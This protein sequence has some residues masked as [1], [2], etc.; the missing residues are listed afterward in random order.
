MVKPLK[1]VKEVENLKNRFMLIQA[2]SGFG[3][4]L[5]NIIIGLYFKKIYNYDVYFVDTISKHSK[6]ENKTTDEIFPKLKNNFIFISNQEGNYIANLPNLKWINFPMQKLRNLHQIKKFIKNDKIFFNTTKLYNLVYDMW[7]YIDHSIL[8]INKLTINK[9]VLQFVSANY[10]AV[11]IRYG[12]KLYYSLRNS[13]PT[14]KFQFIVYTPEYYYELINKIKSKV[15][16]LTDSPK[17]VNE[18]LVKKYNLKNVIILDISTLDSFYM[19][20]MANTLIMSHSTFSYA[21][22]LLSPK[23][24]QVIYCTFKDANKYGVVD[25][26]IFPD[27]KVIYN[28]KYILNFNQNLLRKMYEFHTKYS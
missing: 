6:T 10:T 24:Q 9:N 11:H 16:I 5:F 20:M 15:I 21:A 13:N 25:N 27:W 4:K 23:K 28:K 3:N 12:D 7:K 26:L 2:Y 8:E 19:L 14:E 1:N 22:N 17:T 18:F